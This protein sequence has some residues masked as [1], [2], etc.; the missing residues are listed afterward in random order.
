MK[1]LEHSGLDLTESGV[2]RDAFPHGL[3]LTVV[4]DCTVSLSKLFS[5][6]PDFVIKKYYQYPLKFVS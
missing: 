6:I 5:R 3:A 4:L 2:W 1:S